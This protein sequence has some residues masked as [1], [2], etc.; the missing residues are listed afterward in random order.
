MTRAS[1]CCCG[2]PLALALAACAER[3]RS[4]LP[5]LG[6]G[7][8]DLRQPR[9]GRPRRDAV[10]A[11]RRAVEKGAPLFTRRSRS[12]GGRCRDGQGVGDQRQA[13]LSSAPR[14]C[15]RPRPARRRRFDDA[16]AAL[17]TAEARLSSAQTRL[18]RRK[19][20]SPVDRQRCSRST[21]GRARWCRPGG[22]WF[23]CCRPATSRC[24][25]SCR[26]PMLPRDCARRAG[27]DP[28]RRLQGR[29]CRR[30]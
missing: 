15:S 20:A 24:G 1:H 7:R 29:A 19:V 30:G 12:A 18:A 28:L 23:R 10:G 4:R 26:K 5:G 9:R 14:R 25:S 6:R 3:P 27:D 22:R 2:R 21:T 11:R 13:G 17:R 8:S 16:E